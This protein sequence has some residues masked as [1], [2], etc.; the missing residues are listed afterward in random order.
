MGFEILHGRG[1]EGGSSRGTL[2][3]YKTS[4][5][6]KM[7]S[8]TFNNEQIVF[9]SHWGWSTHTQLNLKNH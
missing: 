7:V 9:P 6:K 3:S 8:S 1:V 5:R 4:F 2:F